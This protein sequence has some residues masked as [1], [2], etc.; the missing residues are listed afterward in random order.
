M[1]AIPR[2]VCPPQK[3]AADMRAHPPAP[4]P[5]PPELLQVAPALKLPVSYVLALRDT[6]GD[7]EPG[8]LSAVHNW[9]PALPGALLIAAL[10][11]QARQISTFRRPNKSLQRPSVGAT[12]ALSG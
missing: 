9:Q 7:C 2:R 10:D 4:L 6:Q 11:S 3:H 12:T 1:L 5:P 8:M